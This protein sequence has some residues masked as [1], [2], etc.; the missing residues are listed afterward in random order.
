MESRQELYTLLSGAASGT[1]SCV[2]VIAAPVSLQRAVC[3]VAA[4]P[5]FIMHLYAVHVCFSGASLSFAAPPL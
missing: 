1:A 4:A 3:V 5:V 2:W